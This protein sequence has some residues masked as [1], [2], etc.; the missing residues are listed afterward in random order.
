MTEV[1]SESPAIH[2]LRDLLSFL[3]GKRKLAGNMIFQIQFKFNGNNTT[4]TEII[5]AR[6]RKEVE[7]K[8]FL[9]YGEINILEVVKL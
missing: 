2:G 3:E 6:G 5:S 8:L 1:F 7:E 9:I 4:H